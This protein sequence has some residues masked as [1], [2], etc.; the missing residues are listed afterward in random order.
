MSWL[1]TVGFQIVSPST[2]GT[3]A[4]ITTTP[5]TSI[6][7]QV[8]CS[9][10]FGADVDATTPVQDNY[11]NTWTLQ[12]TITGPAP[13]NKQRVYTAQAILGGPGHTFTINLGGAGFADGNIGES[14]NTGILDGAATGGSDGAATTTHA[15][16][17]FT[18][19]AG[20]DWIQGML[21]DSGVNPQT[22]TQGAGWTKGSSQPDGSA[23]TAAFCEFQ[24][25]LAG[26]STSAPFS[27][28]DS[29][30][31]VWA[32][33]GFRTGAALP[34]QTGSASLQGYAPSLGIF[35]TPQTA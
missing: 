5:G 17:T 14:S 12:T 20:S 15:G 4:P 10:A 29:C 1:Q 7:F 23:G 3:S 6:A 19:A 25:G 13:G 16:A 11:G 27:T 22:Q 24:S 21:S 26:G 8:T 28:G 35:I 2:T 30:T 9:P 31:A 18:A 32:A 34:P 33:V